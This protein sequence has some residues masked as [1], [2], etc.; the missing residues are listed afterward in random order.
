MRERQPK[1]FKKGILAVVF[2]IFL[3]ISI[4]SLF[5]IGQ[6]YALVAPISVSDIG[7]KVQ[8]AQ[9]WTWEKLNEISWKALRQAVAVAF[10]TGLRNYLSQ[11]AQMRA[12]QIATGG[13]GQTSQFDPRSVGQLWEDT[14]DSVGGFFIEAVGESIWGEQFNICDPSFSIKMKIGLGLQQGL[15]KPETPECTWSE[16]KDNWENYDYGKVF[17]AALDPWSNELGAALALNIGFLEEQSK[18]LSQ[19]L[20][21]RIANQGWFDVGTTIGDITSPYSELGTYAAKRFGDIQYEKLEQKVKTKL[22]CNDVN[23]KNSDKCS[24]KNIQRETDKLYKEALEQGAVDANVGI[25]TFSG[26]LV[27]LPGSEHQGWSRDAGKMLLEETLNYTGEALADAINTFVNTLLGKWIEQMLSKGVTEPGSG[28]S[29]NYELYDVISG[30][31]Y[32]TAPKKQAEERFAKAFEPTLIT[33]G[34]Y[35]LLAALASCPDRENPGVDNCVIDH[36][37]RTAIEQKLTVKEALDKGLLKSDLPFGFTS[38]GAEPEFDQGYPYRSLIILRKYRIIPVGWEIAAEYIKKAGE[39]GILDMSSQITLTNLVNAF[40]DFD[41]PFYG[42]VDPNWVL[43]APANECQKQGVGPQILDMQVEDGVDIDGDGKYESEG[44]SPPSLSVA[45]ADDYCADSVGCLFEDDSGNCLR[46]GYCTEEKRIWNFNGA[47][48]CYEQYN[49]CLAFTDSEGNTE[50]FLQNSLDYNGCTADNAGCLWYCQDYNATDNVWKCTDQE[51]VLATCLTV[52]GC[53]VTDADTGESCTIAYGGVHCYTDSGVELFYSTET[54]NSKA[55]IYFDNDVEECNDSD[56]GCS[57]FIRTKAGLGT[58]LITNP[59]FELYDSSY[60]LDDGNR[61]DLSEWGWSTT[62]DSFELISDSENGSAALKLDDN[63]SI[64]QTSVETGTELRNRTFTLSFSAKG[65]DCQ[66]EYRISGVT[67]GEITSSDDWQYYSGTYTFPDN[68]TLTALVVEFQAIDDSECII[69]AIK[70]EESNTASGYTDYGANNEV[71]LLKAPDYYECEGYTT[72]VSGEDYDTQEECESSPYPDKYYWR[73]D[74]SQCVKSGSEVC[75]QYALYCSQDEVGCALYTPAN[76]DPELGGKV[77]INDYCPAECVGYN[78]FKESASNFSEEHFPLYFIPDTANECSAQEVGCEEFTNLDEVARGGEGKEYYSYIRQCQKPDENECGTYYTWVGSDATGYQLKSYS[79]KKDSET[80]APEEITNPHLLITGDCNS[81]QDAIDNPECKQFFDVNGNPYYAFFKNTITCSDEC[82]PYR[83]TTIEV[84]VDENNQPIT[85]EDTCNN[86]DFEG[87]G[88][89]EEDAQWSP[90]LQECLLCSRYGGE[91]RYEN[92]G[93]VGNEECIFETIPSQGVSCDAN[94]NGCREYKGN[95]SSNVY[96]AFYDDFEGGADFWMLGETSSESTVVGGHSLKSV[97]GIVRS[98]FL[99]SEDTCEQDGGCELSSENGGYSCTVSNGE[100]YCGLANDVF[101]KG[102]MYLISFWAKSQSESAEIDQF[103]ILKLEAGSFVYNFLKGENISLSNEWNNYNFGPFII[104]SDL[105]DSSSIWIGSSAGNEFYIDNFSIKEVSEYIY[106]IKDSWNTPESCDQDPNGVDS[107]QYM[108]GCQ[109]YYDIDNNSVYLKSF[110]QLCRDE[111][112]GCEAFIDTHNS[113]SP[114]KEVYNEGDMGEVTIDADE[115]VYLVNDSNKECPSTSKGCTAY[116]L[117]EINEDDEVESY[118][119]VYFYNDPD[120]YASSMCLSTELYCKEYTDDEGSTYEFKDP[121]YKVCDYRDEGGG[122]YKL[123][124]LSDEPDCPVVESDIGVQ[125]PAPGVCSGGS[126][127]G[128]GCRVDDDCKGGT[129]VDENWVGRCDVSYSGCSEYI[130]PLSDISKNLL[131]NPTFEQDVDENNVPDGWENNGGLSGLS[132][133]YSDEGIEGSMAVKAVYNSSSSNFSQGISLEPDTVYTVSG[134]V[135]CGSGC[136][137]EDY[138]AS[139]IIYYEDTGGCVDNSVKCL[140]SVDGSM[141]FQYQADTGEDIATATVY[142]DKENISS[143]DYT[144]FSGRF[145]SGDI[146]SADI[147]IGSTTPDVGL[148]FDNVS[149]AETGIYYKLADSVDKSSCTSVDFDEGCVLFNDRSNIDYSIG[150]GDFSHL[151]YDADLSPNDSGGPSVS[152][153]NGDDYDA[154]NNTGGLCDSSDIIKVDQDRECKQ[155]LYCSSTTTLIDSSGKEQE[156]CTDFGQCYSFDENGMCN[157]FVLEDKEMLTFNKGNVSQ[158]A[159]LSGYSKAGYDWGD[160]IREEGY[161]PVTQMDEIGG[162]V[163]VPNGNFEDYSSDYQPFDWYIIDQDSWSSD[164]FYIVSD[165]YEMQNEFGSS[166]DLR[167]PEG[168][169]ILAV[170]AGYKAVSSSVEVASST[171]YIISA[172]INTQRMSSGS[173]K[174][175]ISE[176][177]LNGNMTSSGYYNV[178]TLNAGYDWTLL[179]NNFTT[180]SKAAKIKIQLTSEE[181]AEGRF[182]YDNIQIVSVLEPR[183][184]SY[185][186][187]G[188]FN[189]D[190]FIVPECRLYP[191]TDSLSCNYQDESGIIY[192]GWYGYCLEHDTKNPEYCLLWWPAEIIAGDS[193][194]GLGIEI[195]GYEDRA[196]LYYCLEAEGNEFDTGI[197]GYG[198]L[199]YDETGADR[200][201]YRY[202]IDS[203]ESKESDE[204]T[205]Y[206]VVDDY[207]QESD[208]MQ[209]D[210]KSLFLESFVDDW[211]SEG[212]YADNISEIDIEILHYDWAVDF[213]FAGTRGIVVNSLGDEFIHK[214]ADYD[215]GEGDPEECKL[216]HSVHVAHPVLSNYNKAGRNCDIDGESYNADRDDGCFSTK[217][218]LHYTL[219]PNENGEWEPLLLIDEATDIKNQI[220]TAITDQSLE[221]ADDVLDA[222]GGTNVVTIDNWEDEL[223]D[224]DYDCG[225]LVFKPVFDSDTGKLLDIEVGGRVPS[226]TIGQYCH[227]YDGNWYRNRDSTITLALR[228]KIKLAPMCK[229]V[230]NVVRSDGEN[231][232]WTGRVSSGSTYTLD[233]LGYT[234]STDYSPFGSIVAPDPQDNPTAWDSIEGGDMDPL[235]A[236]EPDTVNYTEPYQ[237]R[238]GSPYSCDSTNG[239]CYL[240]DGSEISVTSVD[241]GIDLLKQLFATSYGAWEWVETTD[242]SGETKG[243]YQLVDGYDWTVPTEMCDEDSDEDSYCARPPKV[244]NIKVNGIQGKVVISDSGYVTLTFNSD[245]DANQLPLTSYSIDW[246]DGDILKMGNLQILD[247]PDPSNPH[248]ATHMYSYWDLLDKHSRGVGNIECGTDDDV[249]DDVA[250]YCGTTSCCRVSPRVQIIDNWGWCNGSDDKSGFYGSECQEN[251]WKNYPNDYH[252]YVKEANE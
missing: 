141:K 248:K 204:G 15:Y 121:R 2:F 241:A 240:P 227:N 108:L 81:L 224:E 35:D 180:G 174:I 56:V 172:Y 66:G 6:V 16:M 153:S 94:A 249:A 100:Q 31:S 217:D 125:Y 53:P 87:D 13:K 166:E 236:L 221:G 124:S 11:L 206:I 152:C 142:L 29:S 76:G 77:G 179:S 214:H 133:D 157:R 91:L 104:D 61:D 186:Y 163:S 175:N 78:T 9:K 129:C 50:G 7:L 135:K 134:Y 74:I 97:S 86:L 116:G 225:F 228:I 32:A 102:K 118:E 146:T 131:Y 132:D 154:E 33:S 210:L 250:Y 212:I 197:L 96:E 110:S 252:I 145:Y 203:G 51:Y 219:E 3:S 138:A 44:D 45:R 160:G 1:N 28:S 238:A 169:A 202:I 223:R 173:A 75:D 247:M 120:N 188:Q 95:A 183:D 137:S 84:A 245:V 27:L 73:S 156:M 158:L 23:N 80:G 38:S 85:N 165:P 189:S 60:A 37:F 244:S 48:S 36:D 49:T 164:Y 21:H 111:V 122:W 209:G 54:Y 43:K 12:T 41:S 82:L 123:G 230:V 200:Y 8:G 144:R 63:G 205:V 10:K 171:T 155:W 30:S 193:P 167:A 194:T 93:V 201:Y 46:Y 185:T 67:V 105:P 233:K 130:D 136:D 92:D 207:F 64:L 22:G 176:Y 242:E 89:G 148:W 79:L 192:K 65:T 181:D 59:S 25:D 4:V 213:R 215:I 88:V 114:F 55:D 198:A 57:M 14:V 52:G 24:E 26:A 182:Y 161:Y 239:S 237:V 208:F 195:S 101:S 246:G 58:N 71:Y 139:I 190:R 20:T 162:N 103:G 149:L 19:A 128:L 17:Q 220:A 229:K 216:A 40:D 68:N 243:S 106:A 231:K 126:R 222:C 83:K 42:L 170:N 168:R 178:L 218:S 34:P 127:D 39:Q 113:S 187:T 70:L 90:D 251:G 232:A 235:Y 151:V 177:D 109:E 184:S 143:D 62:A 199:V 147:A 140:S 119:T 196:P 150:E 211:P 115:I 226:G 107:P 69:D 5:G 98:M 117:P 234:Y 112:V 18:A 159:N 72:I 47:D 99:H 191:D